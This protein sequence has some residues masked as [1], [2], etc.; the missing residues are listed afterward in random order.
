VD[1]FDFNLSIKNFSKIF[2]K[3]FGF[4]IIQDPIHEDFYALEIP[5]QDAFSLSV[6][7]GATFLV[8]PTG[9][10]FRDRLEV[11]IHRGIFQNNKFIYSPGLFGRNLSGFL[12]PGNSPLE[13][14]SKYPSIQN[15]EK[16]LIFR[17]ISGKNG[18][19]IEQ[20]TSEELIKNSLNPEEFILFKYSDTFTN[21]EPFFEYLSCKAFDKNGLFTESQTPWFQQSYQG[22]TGGIPDYSSFYIREF[23]ELNKK[24]LLPNFMIIQNL[25]TLF[26]WRGNH[27][28]EDSDYTFNIGE[29]KSS[30]N[31]TNNAL[32][33]LDKY[34]N[35]ELSEKL[36]ATLYDE[37]S[38][39]AKYGLVNI[40]DNFEVNITEPK[41]LMSTQKNL[42]D[43]DRKWIKNYAKIYLLANLPF[44]NI[45][46]YILKKID[47]KKDKNKLE[48]F[49]LLTAINKSSFSEIVDLISSK[50]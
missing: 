12:T 43:D 7:Q 23:D 38:L 32:E 18:S 34:S 48:S 4:K 20:L 40:R 36:F 37:K 13:I 17:S 25:S 44:D 35:V 45:S 49:D 46:D 39:P 29:V 16:K 3:N 50:M 9:I 30:K 21:I 22:F 14:F 6:I 5:A 41:S 27:K 19:N 26:A 28:I 15:G 33:Q 8:I 11:F 2:E 24:K 1:L 10:S 31:Y 47:E 42:R